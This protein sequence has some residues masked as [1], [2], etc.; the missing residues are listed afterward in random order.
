MY[1]G[2]TAKVIVEFV[3]YKTVTMVV[4]SCK[5][6]VYST[7]RGDYGAGIKLGVYP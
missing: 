2:E 3:C 6:L 4:F 7:L 5:S 1:V